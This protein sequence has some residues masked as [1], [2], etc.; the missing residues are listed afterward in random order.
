[1]STARDVIATS[2]DDCTCYPGGIN[3]A[4]Y[5]GPQEHCSMHGRPSLQAVAIL[6]ALAA[7][8]FVVIHARRA[9]PAMTGLREAAK[10]FIAQRDDFIRAIKASP[11][12]DADYWRWQGHA[13]ARRKFR[14]ALERKGIDVTAEPALVVEPAGK[15][16]DT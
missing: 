16:S 1:V 7:A 12:D 2:L 10:A 6:D 14:E 3:P 13:E 4:D 5:E 9:A 8:G 11:G 15:E